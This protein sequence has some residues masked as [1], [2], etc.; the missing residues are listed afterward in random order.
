M[1]LCVGCLFEESDV[2]FKLFLEMEYALFEE[3]EYA[4]FLEM[5]YALFE[6]RVF[7]NE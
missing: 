1:D 5:E 3:M 4:L 6:E 2:Y 7:F